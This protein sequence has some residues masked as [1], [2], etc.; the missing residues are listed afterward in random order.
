MYIYPVY[1]SAILSYNKQSDTTSSQSATRVT[2]FHSEY[3]P[4]PGDIDDKYYT[5]VNVCS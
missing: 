4:S 2:E 3:N 1:H 5:N